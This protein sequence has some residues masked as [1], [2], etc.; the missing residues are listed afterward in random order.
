MIKSCILINISVEFPKEVGIEDDFETDHHGD[1]GSPAY[2]DNTLDDYSDIE[3]V[4]LYH[5]IPDV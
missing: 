1:L 2:F 5:I 4:G 3:Q